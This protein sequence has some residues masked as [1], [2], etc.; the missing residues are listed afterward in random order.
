M[1]MTKV[2]TKYTTHPVSGKPSIRVRWNG[3]QKTV[4]YDLRARDAHDAAIRTALELPAEA[5]L[6]MH[7]DQK[8]R[9]DRGYVWLA[10]LAA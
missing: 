7:P 4:S 10:E 2:T 1:T 8:R 5:K 6:E 9:P 3:R